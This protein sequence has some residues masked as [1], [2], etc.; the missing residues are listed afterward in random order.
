MNCWRITKD[1]DEWTCFSEVGTKLEYE[2]YIITEEKYLEAIKTFWDETGV[3]QIYITAL[4]QWS[5][6]VESQNARKSLS[7]IWIGKAIKIDE[8]L[9]LAQHTLRNVCWCKVEIKNRFFVHF[10]YDY[11]MYIGTDRD[12]QKAIAKT[13]QS[14]LN[15]EE[16]L[17]PYK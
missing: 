16:C 3:N 10:G 12:C 14:G 17:S 5:D 9:Q 6:G 1:T 7:N 13:Q 15:V 11:Y 4:E 8:L 2:E